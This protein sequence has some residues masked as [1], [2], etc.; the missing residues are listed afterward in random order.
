MKWVVGNGGQNH[1]PSSFLERGVGAKR[2]VV[3]LG[4]IRTAEG[5][6]A[7][8]FQR[9]EIEFVP[10]AEDERVI[11]DELLAE[12]RNHERGREDQQ[13]PPSALDRAEL[14]KFIAGDG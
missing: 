8:K 11:V 6:T 12:Q 2:E 5:L 9:R 7:V 14:P 10:V 3:G 13:R 4:A 1:P